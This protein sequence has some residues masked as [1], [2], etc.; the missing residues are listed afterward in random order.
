MYSFYVNYFGVEL[1]LRRQHGI[2][3]IMYLDQIVMIGLGGHLY[4]PLKPEVVWGHPPESS[5]KREA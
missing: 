1:I 2:Y 4:L 5:A 3:S